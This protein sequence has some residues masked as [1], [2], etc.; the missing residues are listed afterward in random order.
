MY[1]T[2]SVLLGRAMAAC[3]VLYQK[4]LSPDH[5][6]FLRGRYP[7]GCCRFY[8]SCLEYTR[9]AMVKHGIIKGTWLFLRR[10]R[11]CHPWAKGGVD[12]IP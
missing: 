4:T 6:L 8:P 3:I 11:K 5:G 10:L 7:N 9:Q 12:P 1:H 2:I